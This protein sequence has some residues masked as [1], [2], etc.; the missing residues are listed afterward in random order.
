MYHLA[1][2]NKETILINIKTRVRMPAYLLFSLNKRS[3]KNRMRIAACIFVLAAALLPLAVGMATRPPQESPGQI[4][5][6]LRIRG[7]SITGTAT[8]AWRRELVRQRSSRANRRVVGYDEE[9]TGCDKGCA[10]S[11]LGTG[12]TGGDARVRGRATHNVCVGRRPAKDCRRIPATACSSL[13]NERREGKEG[14]SLGHDTRG[15]W[16]R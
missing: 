15:I 5:P 6:F 3:Q 8:R 16:V 4:I 14:S 7:E 12:R 2:N 13:D 9:A 1:P 11:L 10:V